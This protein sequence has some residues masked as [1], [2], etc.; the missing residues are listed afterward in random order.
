[1]QIKKR[2]FSGNQFTV[3]EEISFTSA[4]TAKLKNSQDEEVIINNNYGYCIL[5]CFSV[6]TTLSTLIL[7]STCKK[8]IKFSRAAARGLGFKIALQCECEQV[9]YIQS[10][11]FINKAFEVNRRIVAADRDC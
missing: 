8:E 1:M 9:R 11:P 3:E 7:C 5:E 4:S 2:R 6:F 10:S